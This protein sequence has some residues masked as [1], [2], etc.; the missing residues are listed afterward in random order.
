MQAGDCFYNKAVKGVPTH[1][2]IVLS[3]PEVD[4]ENVVLVNITDANN[5]DDDTCELTPDDWGWIKKRS[6]VNYRD[7]KLSTLDSLKNAASAGL[8]FNHN[9]APIEIPDRVRD[10][11]VVSEET[12]NACLEVLRRQGFA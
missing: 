2:W 11:A 12:K 4:A 3:D 7:I 1:P 6:R 9:T 5:C 10:G 8:L